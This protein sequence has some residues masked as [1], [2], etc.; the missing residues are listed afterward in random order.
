MSAM[1]KPNKAELSQIWAPLILI[2]AQ[3]RPISNTL[4]WPTYCEE[5]GTWAVRSCLPNLGHK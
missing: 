2:L 1:N 3:I 4:L 5:Y